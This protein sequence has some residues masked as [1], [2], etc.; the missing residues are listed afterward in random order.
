M[1]CEICLRES[2]D[3]TC[4]ERHHLV[5]GKH[6]RAKV[7]RKEDYIIVCTT[8]GDQ[9]HLMFDN[10]EL[11]NRFNTLA[12]LQSAMKTF[13]NWVSHRPLESKVSMKRKK[14]KL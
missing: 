3:S 9:I 6:R 11:R 2:E 14:R 8:C 5:P 1:R 4:F 13:A 7:D 10:V 12:S